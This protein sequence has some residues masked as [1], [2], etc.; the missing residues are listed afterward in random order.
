MQIDFN[1]QLQ[2]HESSIRVMRDSLSKVIDSSSK[3]EVRVPVG[4]GEINPIGSF[5]DPNES[6]AIQNLNSG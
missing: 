1:E 2:K 6:E 4:F 5:Q 3:D